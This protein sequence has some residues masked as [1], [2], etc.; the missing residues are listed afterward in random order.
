MTPQ[1]AIPSSHTVYQRLGGQSTMTL[2][3]QPVYS[4][5]YIRD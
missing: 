4:N 5:E 3:E 2:G 1:F